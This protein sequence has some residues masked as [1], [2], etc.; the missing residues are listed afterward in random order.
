MS[1]EEPE[2]QELIPVRAD[3]EV[4]RAVLA[5]LKPL[6]E[7]FPHIPDPPANPVDL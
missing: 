7:K 1:T 2:F 6:R 4:L 3:K 5:S